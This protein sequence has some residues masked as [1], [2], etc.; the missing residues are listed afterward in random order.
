MDGK[1]MNSIIKVVIIGL[2]SLFFISLIMSLFGFGF[3]MMGGMMMMGGFG[4]LFPIIAVGLIIYF[5]FR[6]NENTDED[7]V[8][9][10]EYQA[11]DDLDR[12]Y[13]NGEISRETYLL[14]KKDILNAGI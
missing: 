10:G 13:A 14:V 11:Q 7:G 4:M 2:I 5:I 6:N 8:L 1:E 12:R 9:K 3:G